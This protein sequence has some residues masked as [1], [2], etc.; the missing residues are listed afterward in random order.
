MP[1]KE[2]VIS[3]EALKLESIYDA[4][5]KVSIS[6]NDAIKIIGRTKLERLVDRGLIRVEKSSSNNQHAK[7]KCN[8]SDVLRNIENYDYGTDF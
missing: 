7:W 1:F 2:G 8:A 6:K 4:V 5:D 3:K